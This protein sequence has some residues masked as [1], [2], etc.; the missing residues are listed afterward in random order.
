MFPRVDRTEFKFLIP[1]AMREDVI[2]EVEKHT[3]YDEEA[4]GSSQYPIISQYYDNAFRDCYWEKQ[5]GQKSRR[6]LRIRVY[7]S[8][9]GKM[10]PTTFIEVKHKCDGRGVKRRLRLPMEDAL[11]LAEGK[12]GKMLA[13][14][15]QLSRYERMVVDEILGLVEQRKFKFLCTMRYDRQAFVGGADAPDLRVTFDTGIA[16]R[17]EELELRADDKRFEHYLVPDDMC[18]ME[19]KTCSVV[20]TWLRELVGAKS[21]VRR[22]FSK[23]CTALENHDP[24][25]REACYGPNS[26]PFPSVD[27]TLLSKSSP[28]EASFGK[29]ARS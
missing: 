24:V 15:G 7:G 21:L 23:F 1:L 14:G 29:M 2:F 16:C 27:R 3:G 20:P 11:D 4:G 26:V 8:H 5:R 25:I 28:V 13:D 12:V 22:S 17:F 19:V 9:D 18:I 6:K 10:P